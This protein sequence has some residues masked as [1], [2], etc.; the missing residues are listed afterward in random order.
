MALDG[1]TKVS[2]IGYSLATAPQYGFI[3]PDVDF[4]VTDE[5]GVGAVTKWTYAGTVEALKHPYENFATANF[6]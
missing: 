3:A 5:I 2:E 4:Y 6:G 1:T